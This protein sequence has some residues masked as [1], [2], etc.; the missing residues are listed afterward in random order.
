MHALLLLFLAAQAAPPDL[1]VSE[2]RRFL[3]KADGSPF[4]WL[5]DTAWELFHRLR[6][7]EA[8]DYL[9]QRAALGFTVIQAVALA[10]FD[11]LKAP[12]AYGHTPLR[13]NDP[14]RPDVKDGPA[15][16]YWDH[17]DA[18]VARAN[19]HGLLVGLLPTWGDKW[20]RKWGQG[21]EIFGPENAAVYGDWIG[22]RY[23]DRGI[24]W[25]LGGDRPVESDRHREIIR[26]MARA[27]RKA[28]PGKLMTFHPMGGHGSAESFHDDEWLDFNMR[29]NGHG[30][31][32]ASYARLKP[33]YD[34]RPVKPVLDGEPIYE[35]HPINFK[36]KENGHS[37]AAHVRRAAYW[38]L[39]GGAFGHTY[40]HHSV[41]SF[42]DEGRA[43]VN[44]PL[45]NWRRAIE[46]PGAKQMRHARAL[47]ESRPFL[48]RIPDDSVIVA[49]D[50]PSAVPGTGWIRF[51]ATR[52]AGGSFVLVYVPVGRPF[53]VRMETVSGP[54]KAWWFDPRTGT[55]AAVGD[56]PNTGER[57]FVTPTPGE[58]L[59]WILVLDDASKGFPPPGAR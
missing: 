39:F 51:A 4:F 17:V 5:G 26:A 15:N 9:K 49:T 30:A 3:L 7:E 55:A 2:N 20:N 35:D 23:K 24:V 21:P 43:P 22:R 16:D 42:H 38:D 28:S 54:V 34:R 32:H 18:V 40:G 8:E 25:I 52:D 19:A 33:D 11:G 46:Q 53:K 13:E 56:F 10:E 31:D 57:E 6:L 59:D 12:N 47:L 50:P 45:L 48:T 36:P 14:A 27:I 37:T 44:H 58:T 41:W 29:Q 1:K